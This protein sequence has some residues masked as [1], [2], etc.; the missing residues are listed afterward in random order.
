MTPEETAAVP[1]IADLQEKLVIS[2]RQRYTPDEATVLA[3]FLIGDLPHNLEVYGD[4]IMGS[5]RDRA[6]LIHLTDFAFST[7]EVFDEAMNAYL[8]NCDPDPEAR[9]FEEGDREE[10]RMKEEGLGH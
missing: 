9:A 6:N 7:A 2:F 4:F 10:K 3:D 5:V 8:D 1:F